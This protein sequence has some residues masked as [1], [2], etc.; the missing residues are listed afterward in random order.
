V[1][2]WSSTP[3]E[4]L[5]ILPGEGDRYVVTEGPS[6]GARGYFSRGDD[7]SVDG[8]HVGGRFATRT[9]HN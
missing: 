8:M 6:K 3:P 7:G 2:P 9:P 1:A 5:G 4:P